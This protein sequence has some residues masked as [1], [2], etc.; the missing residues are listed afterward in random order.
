MVVFLCFLLALLI[1]ACYI[2]NGACGRARRP[3]E[4]VG[5][6]V[7]DGEVGRTADAVAVDEAGALGVGGV[8]NDA[9]LQPPAV[10]TASRRS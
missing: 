3:M 6:A 8:V 9:K 5:E 10:A 1:S 2:D 7:G 4:H